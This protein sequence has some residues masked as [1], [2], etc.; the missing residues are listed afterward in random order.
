M[1]REA[2][3]VNAPSSISM[4]HWK[5]H[6]GLSSEDSQQKALQI[7]PKPFDFGLSTKAIQGLALTLEGVDD[8]HGS[9]GLAT[10]VLGVGDGITNNILKEDL[11]DT[12]GL[13]V[14]ETRDAL[15]A[16][17]TGEAADGGLG[18]ALDVVAQDL[19]VTLG[20]AL[21]KAL[22]SFSAS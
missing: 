16:A 20:A 4:K 22:A 14:D 10:S 3:Q 15:D 12:T 8:V 2:Y 18:D 21:S 7:T 11:E 17:T 9:D 1:S 5:A 6:R 19:A 13:L